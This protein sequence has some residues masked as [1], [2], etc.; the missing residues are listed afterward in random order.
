MG[1][2]PSHPSRVRELK[3][4]S[5]LIKSGT[6]RSHPSRVRELKQVKALLKGILNVSHPSRV[7][8]LKRHHEGCDPPPY[9]GRTPRGC[10]N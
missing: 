7:R 6:P 8:E 10:V 5:R 2:T 9:G 4:G 1:N 3:L